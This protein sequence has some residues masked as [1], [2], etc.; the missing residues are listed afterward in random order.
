MKNFKA[1]LYLEYLGSTKRETID[2]G[3]NIRSILFPTQIF[4]YAEHRQ[5]II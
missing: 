3:S 1:K 2:L 5:T 4:A